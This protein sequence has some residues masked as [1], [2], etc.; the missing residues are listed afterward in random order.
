[1]TVARME[2]A[3][4]DDQMIEWNTR[5]NEMKQQQKKKN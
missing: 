1:M 5:H 2:Q 4:C 3:L